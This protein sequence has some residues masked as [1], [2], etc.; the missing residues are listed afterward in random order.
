MNNAN[1]LTVVTNSIKETQNNSKR[2]SVVEYFKKKLGNNGI[3][4]LQEIHYT[5]NDERIWKIDFN[6][7]VFY[8]H[9]TSQSCGVLI[10][11]FWK[12]QLFG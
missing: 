5:F 10:A 2:L 6:V 3:L 11:F 8:S 1:C 7:P 9:S 12:S 4:F